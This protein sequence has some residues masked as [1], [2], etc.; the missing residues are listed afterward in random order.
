MEIMAWATPSNNALSFVTGTDGQKVKNATSFSN[1]KI[2][3]MDTVRGN[4]SNITLL[5]W[6]TSEVYGSRIFPARQRV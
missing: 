4:E 6:T 2:L 1:K 3:Y 5:I